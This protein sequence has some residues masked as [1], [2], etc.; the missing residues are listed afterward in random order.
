MT[1][2]ISVNV[3]VGKPGWAFMTSFGVRLL[4]RSI[5]NCCMYMTAWLPVPDG[6]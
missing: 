6:R 2:S 4:D 3:R 5:L 1:E